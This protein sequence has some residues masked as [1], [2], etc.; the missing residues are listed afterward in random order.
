MNR[1][2]EEKLNEIIELMK[3]R[4]YDPVAQLT[5]YIEIGS[6]DYITRHGGAREKIK[7]IDKEV[8]KLY[9]EKQKIK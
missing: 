7:E 8:V 3:E 6:D 2:P 4:D 9:L 1:T 5:G